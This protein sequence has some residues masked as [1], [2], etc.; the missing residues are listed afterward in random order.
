MNFEAFQKII[1]A[2]KKYLTDNGWDEFSE[3]KFTVPAR[4][5][6]YAGDVYFLQRAFE[7]QMSADAYELRKKGLVIKETHEQK[8]V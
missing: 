5:G 2:Q 8:P 3:G 4:Y 6:V 7:M 1:K